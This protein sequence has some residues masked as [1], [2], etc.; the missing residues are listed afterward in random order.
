L[1]FILE[2]ADDIAYLVADMEDA[3]GKGV[4]TFAMVKADLLASLKQSAQDSQASRQV[5]HILETIDEE[6]FSINRFFEHLRNVL[7]AGATQ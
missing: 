4:L 1:T 5:V 7:I 3:L 2:A 6:I